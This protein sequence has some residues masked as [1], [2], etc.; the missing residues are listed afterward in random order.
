MD[1][2]KVRESRNQESLEGG[3]DMTKSVYTRS[4]NRSSLSPAS[5]RVSSRLAK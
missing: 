1:T 3:F 5:L 2:N 4:F